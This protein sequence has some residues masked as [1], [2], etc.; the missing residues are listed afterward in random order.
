MLKFDN[1]K[2]VYLIAANLLCNFMNKKKL[3][4][5][6]IEKLN[7]QYYMPI[8]QIIKTKQFLHPPGHH[9]IDVIVGE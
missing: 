8:V 4:F 5:L 1:V 2:L 3:S 7:L 6:Q 9:F